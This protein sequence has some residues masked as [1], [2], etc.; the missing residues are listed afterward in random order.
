MGNRSTTRTRAARFGGALGALLAAA[1][2]FAVAPAGASSQDVHFSLTPIFFGSVVLGT[3]TTGQSI[4]TNNSALPLY[5]ISA[6]PT[7]VRG[8]EFHASR[9]TCTGALAPAAQCDIAVVFKPNAKG[10]RASTLSVRFGEHNAQGNVTRAATKDTRI[11]GR[12][13]PPTFTLSDA[14]AGNV[15]LKQIGTASATI[16]NTSTVPLTLR[17][18]HMS[19]VVNNDFRI[20]ATTCPSPVLPGGS[21]S[22]VVT[23]RPHRLGNASATLTASM[24]VVGTHASLVARQS[25]IRGTGTTASGKTPPFELS[26]LDFGQVTVGTTATGSVVLTNTSTKNETFSSD[27]IQSDASGAYAVT[28]NNC[29]TPIA[30]SASCEFT[31]T[32]SPAAAVTH[33]ATFVAKVTFLNAHGV[34]VKAAAQTSLTGKGVNPTFTLSSSGFPTTTVGAT[35]DGT[36][37]VTNTSLVPLMYSSTAFQGADPQSWSQVGNAC[38]GPIAPAASCNLEIAFSPH[39]QGTQAETIQVTLDL[40]VRSHT[41]YVSLRDA[42]VGRGA[43][44]TFKLVAPTLPSTP[45]GVAVTGQATLTNTSNVSLSYD[46]FSMS[47]ANPGDFTVTTTTCS[48]LL[49]PSATCDLT[50]RFDPSISSPGTEHA[51]LKVIVDIAGIAPKVTTSDNVQLTGTES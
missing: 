40:T 37:T 26:A 5:F 25:S 20:S 22:I 3:S 13:T 6:S 12:G 8:A 16:T 36:E 38:G 34:L 45:K 42:L 43:L 33:N 1:S 27:L 32:Y 15:P 48:G 28:G 21:C 23:F 10:L 47:G 30:P 39:V 44:P 14:N 35:S 9:G 50:V 46:S 41:Q 7:G 29:P 11:Q 24:L 19:N 17:G 2:V 49:A 51:S 4:V 18:A 31:I